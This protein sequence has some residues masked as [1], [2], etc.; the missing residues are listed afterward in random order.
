MTA[1]IAQVDRF[2]SLNRAGRV[3]E[4]AGGFARFDSRLRLDPEG[5]WVRVTRWSQAG[6]SRVT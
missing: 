1:K 2:D 4:A 3:A 6:Q 5:I